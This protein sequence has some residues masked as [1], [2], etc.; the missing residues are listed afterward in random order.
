MGKVQGN[1][2]FG[3]IVQKCTIA[4]ERGSGSDSPG[5]VLTLLTLLALLGVNMGRDCS[6]WR[7]EA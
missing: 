5:S 7:Q 6:M 3:V 2:Y 4:A 1:V